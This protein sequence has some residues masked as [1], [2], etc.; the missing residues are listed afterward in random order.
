MDKKRENSVFPLVFRGLPVVNMSLLAFMK[1][2]E[3]RKEFK[4]EIK[5]ELK[6]ELK[7][8]LKQELK[9]ELKKEFCLYNENNELANTFIQ[10]DDF[11][12]GE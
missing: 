10:I 9:D 11:H 4:D 6:D 1:S 12:D 7:K 2:N 5:K 3:S 8:E